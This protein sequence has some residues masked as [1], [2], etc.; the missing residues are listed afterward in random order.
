MTDNE[1]DFRLLQEHP[2][3]F[4]LKYQSLIETI[5]NTFI[6]SGY[7]NYGD[8][9]DLV[10]YVNEE[11]F[12]RLEKIEKQYNFSTLLKTYVSAIIRNLCFE[13]VRKKMRSIHEEEIEYARNISSENNSLHDMVIKE[14]IKKLHYILQMFCKS[15]AKLELC[16]KIIF[17]IKIQPDDFEKYC[18]KIPEKDILIHTEMLNS[19][20]L[21][22]DKMIYEYIT[23]FFNLCEGTQ[24]TTDA[25]RK[26]IKARTNEIIELLNKAHSRYDEETLQ[27]LF[28]K[29]Y[30]SDFPKQNNT[31]I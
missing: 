15:R 10:Q 21:K 17:R 24:N 26:Y 27:I 4:I 30:T 16:M 31:N 25:I 13:K 29:Y 18:S 2:D 6:R 19:G 3:R 11:L 7:F 12:L 23:P 22:T 9:K 28:E 5:V 8:R 20:Q 1:K 14:E